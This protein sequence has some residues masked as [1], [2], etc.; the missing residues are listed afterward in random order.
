MSYNIL[1]DCYSQ[2]FMFKYV[3]HGYLNF[4]YRSVRILQEIKESNSDIL[5][6]QVRSWKLTLR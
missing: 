2:Y 1:A 6:L 4:R 5:C 3:K